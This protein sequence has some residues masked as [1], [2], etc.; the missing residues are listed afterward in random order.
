[1]GLI[2]VYQDGTE[3]QAVVNAMISL[4]VARISSDFTDRPSNSFNFVRLIISALFFKVDDSCAVLGNYAVNNG[5]FLPTFRDNLS[6]QPVG[7][8]GCPEMSV[9]SYHYSLRNY[10]EERSLLSKMGVTLCTYVYTFNVHGSVHRNNILVSRC[11][12]HRVYFI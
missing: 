3:W 11:T 9:K 8:V 5:N 2:H 4:L 6:V 10:A 7:T 12:S 1:V